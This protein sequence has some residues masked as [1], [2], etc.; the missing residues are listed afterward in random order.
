MIKIS[1]KG[2]LMP[3]PQLENLIQII[4][5][6]RDPQTGCPWDLDQTH[7]T[8]LPYLL[9]EAYE[10]ID[11]TE[12]GSPEL[13]KEEIGDVLLQVILHST[14]AKQNN[15]FNLEDVAQNLAEKLVHRHPHVFGDKTAKLSSPEVAEQWQKIKSS[16][17]KSPKSQIPYKLMHNPALETAHLIGAASKKVSFDW[18]NHQQ[19]MH[20][21]E[22]EW[23]EVKTELL[24]NGVYNPDNVEEE[25]GDLLFSVAQLA[26]HL[27]VNAETAL[28]KANQKFLK[29]FHYMEEVAE[30]KNLQLKDLKHDQLED[31]WKLAKENTKKN[32][33]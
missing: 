16:G 13:M 17:K 14:I 26:R 31:L 25:L 27:N 12:K 3:Y 21:V 24:P 2:I 11:A 29:R 19:V 23:Q 32:E 8:L 1:S 30:Q 28:R 10:F 4:E 18:E 5:K 15:T 20:K 9:E 33:T 7:T 22:E 6:L